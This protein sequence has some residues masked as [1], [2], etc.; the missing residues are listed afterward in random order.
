MPLNIRQNMAEITVNRLTTLIYGKPGV[1]KTTL[2]LTTSKP[3]ILDFDQGTRRVFNAD[4]VPGVFVEDWNQDI[5]QVRPDD[6]AD[7]D[8]VIIDTV[9]TA[10]DLLAQ[11]LIKQ[12]NRL[13]QGS[14]ALTQQGYGALKS[15]FANFLGV[16][17]SA[18]ADIVMVAH[19][20]ERDVN[21]QMIHD[22]KAVGST[23]YDVL[24][25]S[26]LVG[27]VFI[28]SG[29]RRLSFDPQ[30]AV[31]GK[32]MGLPEVEIPAVA[33]R[34]LLLG[35]LIQQ[36]RHNANSRSVS[37]RLYLRIL[38]TEGNADAYNALIADTSL[39]P[40][41]EWSNDCKRLL[42]HHSKEAGLVFDPASRSF[43]KPMASAAAGVASNGSA[44]AEPAPPPPPPAPPPAPPEPVADDAPPA[45]ADY[46]VGAA[47]TD[48]TELASPPEP[49]P[50]PEPVG[51]G[52]G[53][54]PLF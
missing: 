34:P 30:Y 10:L 29:T 44:P 35:D 33:D 25:M 15:A 3:I 13:A 16:I 31:Q 37:G 41:K 17:R 54:D 24:Q 18:N 5:G 26:D 2:A 48:P 52:A 36:A 1:G 12:N 39:P 9:G 11:S 7:Y 38:S 50:E 53:S 21:D 51:A 47:F 4:E 49:E 27:R 40:L 28:D 46:P 20:V 32:N 42:D 23:K 6:F 43:V 19:S 45:V 8:T 22:I 14:G